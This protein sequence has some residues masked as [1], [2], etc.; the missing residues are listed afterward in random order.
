MRSFIQ[1]LLLCFFICGC[2][3]EKKPTEQGAPQLEPEI[4]GLH[5]DIVGKWR[6]VRAGG[7]PPIEFYIKSQE[8]DIAAD[9]TWTSKV[10][11]QPPNFASDCFMGQGKWSLADGR[12]ELRVRWRGW[13]SHRGFRTQLRKIIGQAGIGPIDRS[14]WTVSCRPARTEQI[15]SRASTSDSD[16][17]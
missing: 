4:S 5:K 15:Q 3:S 14:T 8:I 2:S 7:K 13:R 17:Q 11:V 16:Q 6:L 1:V 9:G 10:E 12:H